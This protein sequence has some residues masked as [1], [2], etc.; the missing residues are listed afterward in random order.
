MKAIGISVLILAAAASSAFAQQ[1]EVGGGA[2]LSFLPGVSVSGPGGSATTGFKTGPAAGAYLGQN[3][4]PHISGEI[5]YDF[6]VSSLRLSSGGT[7]A[8]FAGLSHMVH[9]DVLLHTNRPGARS[10]MFVALGGGMR[11]F[12]GTGTE[13]AYQPL[14]QFA[15]FTK[16]YAVK[17]MASVG[18]GVRYKLGPRLYL[19]AEFRD[20]ISPFPEAVITPAPGMKI[21]RILQD[22][23][24]MVGISYELAQSER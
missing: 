15:Y 2:G 4:Y 12:Q 1:W 13:A 21:G 14:S 6:A 11:I 5:R 20:Y 9:Y 8:T 23:V 18:A 19:R 16:T 22:F 10:Q 3:L 24:P 17:P 7:E